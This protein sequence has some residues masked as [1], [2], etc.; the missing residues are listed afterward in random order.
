M[1]INEHHYQRIDKGT[2]RDYRA[3]ARRQPRT[4]K[5][6]FG[7][8]H[9]PEKRKAAILDALNSLP[10]GEPTDQIAARHQIPGSTL[11]AWLISDDLLND[12]ANAARK[13][14]LSHEL[15]LRAN[16][17]DEALDPLSLARARE[18]FRAWSWIAERRESQMFG[19]RTEVTTI[20][21]D[22]GDRLRRARER[23]IEGEV[24]PQKTLKDPTKPEGSQG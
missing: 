4:N 11:R 12:G 5:G 15:S 13:S 2:K 16:Q 1:A 14:F 8:I 3:L 21:I 7:L 18:A 17:I 9:D 24:V 19:Q 23:V 22:L 6:T 10:A 20:N